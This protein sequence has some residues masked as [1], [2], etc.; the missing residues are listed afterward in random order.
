MEIAL[1]DEKI[2][3]INDEKN[4]CIH[5]LKKTQK[6]QK[7]NEFTNLKEYL[8]EIYNNR[9]LDANEREIIELEIKTLNEYL[10]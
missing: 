3:I 4:K 5:F 10:K 8:K 6:T 2:N 7:N 9:E 1:E